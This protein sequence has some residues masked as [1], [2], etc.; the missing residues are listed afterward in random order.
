MTTVG[1]QTEEQEEELYNQVRGSLYTM[2]GSSGCSWWWVCMAAAKRR[3]APVCCVVEELY[4]QVQGRDWQ[5]Q[6]VQ[7]VLVVHDDGG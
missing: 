4:D 2:A 6:Q 3:Q 5:Q 7:A 1:K